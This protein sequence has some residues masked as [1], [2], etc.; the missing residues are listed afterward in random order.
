VSNDP[1]PRSCGGSVNRQYSLIE[2]KQ[3]IVIYPFIQA[4]APPSFGEAFDAVSQLGE[5]YDTDEN[6]ILV[7]VGQPIDYTGIR[8]RLGPL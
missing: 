5:C 1:S 7:C 2:S 3:Q 6:A 4:L 8:A